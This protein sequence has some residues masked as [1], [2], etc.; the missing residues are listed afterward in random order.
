MSQPMTSPLSRTLAAL[1]LMVAL[2][3]AS[4]RHDVH[5]SYC[6][7]ELTGRTLTGTVTIYRD[8]FI[9][10]LRNWKGIE[11][12]TLAGSAMLGAVTEF[13]DGHLSATA[14][15]RRLPLMIIS[16]GTDN[17]SMRFTF[18][19]TSAS[20][21]GSMT[22]SNTILFAEYGDQMNLMAVKT[23][24]RDYNFIFTPSK[25]NGSLAP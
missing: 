6:K 2:C 19:Y 13:L 9:K 20:P 7:A 3:G 14:D 5:I 25:P 24:K 4:P 1:P 12:H 16:T 21:I 22:F 15:G 18:S 11:L 8:D 10:A 17:A 23:P